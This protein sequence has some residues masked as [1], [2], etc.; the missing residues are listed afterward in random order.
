VNIFPRKIHTQTIEQV[1][2]T[3]WKPGHDRERAETANWDHDFSIQCLVV[4]VRK[5]TD[6]DIY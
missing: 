5:N 4:M 6:T 1:L 2:L 3:V